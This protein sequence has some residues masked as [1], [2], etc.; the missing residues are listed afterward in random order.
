MWLLFSFS[1]HS[2][3]GRNGCHER[4][5]VVDESERR[6]SGDVFPL[7][8]GGAAGDRTQQSQR[9]RAAADT[10]A[11]TVILVDHPLTSRS[12]PRRERKGNQHSMRREEKNSRK[13]VTWSAVPD[14]PLFV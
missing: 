7:S 13:S 4:D 3:P 8:G 2:L 5:A 6:G 10:I 1:F 12:L 14:A 11:S 9:G